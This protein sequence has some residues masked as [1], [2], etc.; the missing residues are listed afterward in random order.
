MDKQKL[1]LIKK[2]DQSVK[3]KLFRKV[4]QT[5]LLQLPIQLYKTNKIH[6]Q[7]QKI[8]QNLN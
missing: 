5:N 1:F 7:H 2:P 6:Q 3:L 8:N 4:S